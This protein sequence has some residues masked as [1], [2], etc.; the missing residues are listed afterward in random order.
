MKTVLSKSVRHDVQFSANLYLQG[1][2]VVMM[3]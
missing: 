1:G 3:L 2:K